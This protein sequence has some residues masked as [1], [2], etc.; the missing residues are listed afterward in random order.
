MKNNILKYTAIISLL[1]LFSCGKKTVFES[2]ITP[3]NS[4]WNIFKPADFS[5]EIS[6]TSK[7]CKIFFLLKI[8]KTKMKESLIPISVEMKYPNSE[9]RTLMKNLI[10]DSA[11]AVNGVSQFPIQT[12]KEFNLSGKYIYSFSQVTSKYNL[13]GIESIGLRIETVPVRTNKEDEY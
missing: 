7:P 10:I 13:E 3:P 6:D 5:F 8:D 2:T 4:Q 9:K 12:Y 1:F 11:K